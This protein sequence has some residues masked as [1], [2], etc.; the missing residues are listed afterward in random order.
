VAAQAPGLQC[1]RVRV[2]LIIHGYPPR[3]NAGSEVYTQSLA[4][5]L[6]DRHE[7]RVFTRQED[8]FLTQF[9]SIDEPDPGDR[10]VALRVVN[11]AMSRD[12]YRHDGIDTELRRLLDEFPPDVVHVNHVSHLSTTMLRTI[13]ERGL[14]LLYT[15]HDYWLMCP[16]GQFIQRSAESGQEPFPLCDG[17]QDRKCAERCYSLYFSGGQEHYEADVARWTAW[18]AERMANVREMSVLVDRFI[19]PSRHLLARFRDEFGLPASKITFL[20]YGFDLARLSGRSRHPE[21]PFVLGYIGTHIPAKGIHHLL[22]AFSQLQG[23]P[24]L[25]IW[26]RS[27][28]PYTTSLRRI[29]ASLPNRAGSRVQWLG[30]YQ[31]ERIVQEVFDRVDAIVVPSIW[32]ENSPLVIHEA[33]QA[34][35]PVVTAD[36]GGM[37][38][39]VRHEVNGL[40]FKHRDRRA[41][42][43]QMQRLVDDPRLASRLGAHGY[44]HSAS[45]DVPSMQEHALAVEDVYRELLRHKPVS[46]VEAKPGPWRI[47]FD[48]NPDDCN[49]RC[50]MCEEH[51]P[52]SKLQVQRRSS[53]I[54]RRRMNIAMVRR[55]LESCRGSR[56]REVI[57][58]TM[59]E[60]LLYEH[61]DEFIDLCREFG[62]QMN[63][64]T[65][66]TFPKRGARGWA[67]R[68]VP[69]CSDVKISINGASAATQEAIMLG[70][71]L[72]R[73]LANVREF[74][75]VRDAH[76]AAGGNRCRVTFQTTFLDSNVAELPDLVRLAASLGVDRVKGHHLWAHFT[77]IQGLSMRRSLESVERW[78]RIV[79]ETEKAA[80]EHQLPNGQRV[81]LENIH[82]LDPAHRD[83]IAPGGPCPFLGE[84]AW[85][86]AE[87]R[88][89]PCCAPDAQRRTL[90]EFGNLTDKALM[91]IWNSPEYRSLRET[92][93]EHDLCKGCNMRKP[94]G[95]G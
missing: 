62:V 49:L 43:E 34:R 74:V 51:S 15:L 89:N 23:E 92:Y 91:E 61:F 50:V 65:N 80:A 77:Q 54:P 24:I 20:D 14:P 35:V 38:E 63:L 84:E 19:A 29:A 22:D 90:G 6:A 42:A 66:G 39:Y 37:A 75:A 87:G 95:P 55:V 86:S 21:S 25:R 57:P 67:E 44:L 18:V 33:Q 30:E 93:R 56:L 60:P 26:G 72:D 88:F 32:E 79:E 59:G 13:R 8:P 83:D 9:A 70:T 53:G 76:A 94:A 16:R 12:R 45:G 5:A 47:T 68:L 2:L 46:T 73:V 48:T 4:R 28:D 81:L 36:V 64:T 52:H 40:L 10:R 7:V 17:Q 11:N 1:F 58:S 27:R 82:R 31:N 3:Y 85:V 78:N 71:K 69:I 41:L